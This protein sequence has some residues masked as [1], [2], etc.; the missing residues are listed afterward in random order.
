[1]ASTD[2]SVVSALKTPS[3]CMVP[4]NRAAQQFEQPA[5]NSAMLSISA[6]RSS[7]D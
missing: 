1:M 5:T 4:K 3:C 6:M 2:V 7:R